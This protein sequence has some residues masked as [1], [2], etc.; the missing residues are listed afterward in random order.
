MVRDRQ[1]P[2]ALPERHRS[3]ETAFLGAIRGVVSNS[4]AAADRAA[5]GPPPGLP[6]PE[7]YNI[8]TPARDAPQSED[9]VD[10]LLQRVG[11][12]NIEQNAPKASTE[13]KNGHR[14]AAVVV[15]PSL[16][17]ACHRLVY[18]GTP[19]LRVDRL[20]GSL[21]LNMLQSKPTFTDW[22]EAKALGGKKTE[23]MTIARALDLAVHEF[24]ATFLVSTPAEVLLR[25]LLSITLASKMGSYKLASV[26]EEL[27]GDGALAE[28]PDELIKGLSERLK[29]EAKIEQLTKP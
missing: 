9:L 5:F 3:I 13:A 25:R 10:V 11:G 24:G 28:L 22:V 20:A 7:Q 14:P 29:L 12:A 21:A 15:S 1:H 16:V 2:F 6:R 17:Q 18:V 26:L 19:P 8:H 4:A 23:A 27:P